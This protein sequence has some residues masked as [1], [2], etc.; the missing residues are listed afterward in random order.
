M[1]PPA[2]LKGQG[3]ESTYWC[4]V[5]SGAVGSLDFVLPK[6]AA[7]LTVTVGFLDDSSGLRHRVKFEV[8]GDGRFVL[9]ERTVEFGDTADLRADLTGRTR[10]QLRISEVGPA[11]QNISPSRPVWAGPTVT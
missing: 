11:G 3:Y 2:T 5:Y 4:N 10:V 7:L 1:P 9:D 6:P 8:V